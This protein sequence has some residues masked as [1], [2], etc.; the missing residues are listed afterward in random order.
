[1]SL[2]SFFL[3]QL[4]S[5][6]LKDVPEADQERIFSAIEKN[7]ELFQKIGADVQAEMKKGVDQMTA[8]MEI[9]KRY[10]TDLKKLIK[11]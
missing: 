4:L 10:E 3:K 6:K 7:P 8:T 1:M 2:K 9:V 11:N 5:R